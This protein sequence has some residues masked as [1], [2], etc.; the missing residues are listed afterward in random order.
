RR[1]RQTVAALGLD[2]P[3]PIVEPALA[4]Q[5]FGAWT[6]RRW[7]EIEAGAFWADPAE[8]APPEGESFAEVCRRVGPALRRLAEV[9]AGRSV[10]AVIHA[11]SIRAALAEALDL[12]PAAALRLVIEPLSLTRLDRVAGS[13][14]VVAVNQTFPFGN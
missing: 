7:D 5:S 10:V 9:H 4:E 2:R 8:T 11:G 3:A 6:G 13:W 14:R 1:C 12:T